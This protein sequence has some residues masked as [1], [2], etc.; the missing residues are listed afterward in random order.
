MALREQREQLPEIRLVYI[1][2]P[3]INQESTA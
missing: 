1:A 2:A 3:L